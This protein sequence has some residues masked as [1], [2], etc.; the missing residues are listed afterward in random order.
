VVAFVEGKTMVAQTSNPDK[1]RRASSS[2]T[3]A[4][5]GSKATLAAKHMQER[6]QRDNGSKSSNSS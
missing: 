2:K 5:E 6:S 3:S 1:P 4:R